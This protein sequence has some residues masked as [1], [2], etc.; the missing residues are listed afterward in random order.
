MNR[1]EGEKLLGQ[2]FGFEKFHDTQWEVIDRLLKGERV[3][4]IE[5]TGFGK[6]LCFQFPGTQM[7]GLTIV[8][9]PLIA[10]M[11]DQVTKLKEKGILAEA[12]HSQ[13]SREE[14]DAIM[15]NAM[16]GKIK[17]LYI[18]PERIESGD[19]LSVARQ[20]NLAM[21]VIDEAHCVSTW[22]HDFRPA[23]RRIVELVNMLPVDFPVLAVTATATKAVEADIV[24]QIQGDISSLRG[25]LLRP[26]L[27]LLVI[28]VKS[29][30]E[31]M[32]WLAQNLRKIEGTGV[33]YTGTR[34]NTAQYS[35]WLQHT[36]LKAVNY[37][38]GL[39]AEERTEI[40]AGLINN[41]YKC[42]VSTNAL[43]MG[44]D[45]PDIRFVIHTQTPVS[46]IHY[47]QEIGRAGRDGKPSIVVLFFNPDEDTKLPASFIESGKPSIEKYNLVLDGLK[48]GPMG[49]F[50]LQRSA[51][52]KMTW[53]RVIKSDL[54]EQGVVEEV[55][56]GSSKKLALVQDG[57]TFDASPFEALR[58]AKW[59]E[60]EQML[61]YINSEACRMKF[62]CDFLGDEMAGDCGICDNDRNRTFEVVPEPEWELALQEFRSTDYPVLELSAKKSNL[63]NGIA[64]SH[65]M[66]PAVGQALKAI[67]IGGEKA[68]PNFLVKQ[69]LKALRQQANVPKFDL[70]L[71]VPSRKAGTAIES[72]AD[73]LSVNLQ[74]P[75]SNQLKKLRATEP[76]KS[77]QTGLL[78]RDNVKGAFFCEE[79]TSLSGKCILL[80][81]DF[82]DSGYTFKELGRI[83]TSY[84]ADQIFPLAIAKTTAVEA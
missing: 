69:A 47:Y 70:I 21:I 25:N 2:V 74:V 73:K 71:H 84:G 6:S 15:R 54:L 9:S 27:R 16:A 26:N 81:D 53:A 48:N 29:E 8:F 23:Y 33:I 46:P 30:A 3:L 83:L 18:A 39:S 20:L 65:T 75:L 55:K 45:K 22:G 12:L 19:W 61:A 35:Q 17:I 40:E 43:G 31:K 1:I 77:F 32:L 64:A 10:L 36:G 68:F 7:E 63:L 67:R 24:K 78:K 51:N 13:Q 37:N 62:L 14:N 11:R 57:P 49:Q 34:F 4:L 28:K 66:I 50:D 41:T 44:I 76:Q 60:F 72:F 5:K 79:P 58:A 52:L 59:A 80:V 82:C 56:V 38:A 42:V